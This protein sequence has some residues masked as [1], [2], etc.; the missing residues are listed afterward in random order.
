MRCPLEQHGGADYP[1]A[2]PDTRQ[3]ET[4]SQFTDLN[5]A[6]IASAS[7]RHA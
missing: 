6:S 1:A 4:G 7:T 3:P 2:P 5:S